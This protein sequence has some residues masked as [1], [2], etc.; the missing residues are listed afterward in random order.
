MD[1]W[2]VEE[3]QESRI[4]FQR[5]ELGDQKPRPAQLF[6][7][8]PLGVVNG[9]VIFTQ[10]GI[11]LSGLMEA[12]EI[13]RHPMEHLF[14]QTV[15]LVPTAQADEALSAQHAGSD[16]RAWCGLKLFVQSATKPP[17]F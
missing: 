14:R 17:G 12:L 7:E 13:L 9:V 1:G 5:I 10:E 2:G 3:I 15:R 8:G 6:F 4:I 11:E 16:I